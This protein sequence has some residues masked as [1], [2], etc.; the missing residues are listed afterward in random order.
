MKL[1]CPTVC[2]VCGLALCLCIATAETIELTHPH[3]PFPRGI[4]VVPGRRPQHD[5][6]HQDS[7]HFVGLRENHPAVGGSGASVVVTPAAASV[8]ASGSAPQVLIGRI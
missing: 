4:A 2:G 7:T 3:G 8:Q 5:H 1:R 6:T